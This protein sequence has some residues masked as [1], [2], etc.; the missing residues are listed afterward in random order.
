MIQDKNCCGKF[1]FI[2]IKVVGWTD[3]WTWWQYRWIFIW[4]FG[5]IN[6]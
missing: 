4:K 3:W 2:F 1:K 5:M 6:L